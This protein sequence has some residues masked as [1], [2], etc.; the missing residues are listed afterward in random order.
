MAEPLDGT[1]TGFLNMPKLPVASAR[2]RFLAFFLDLIL[3]TLAVYLLSKSAREVFFSWGVYYTYVTMLLTFLYFALFDSKIGRGRTPGKVLLGLTVTDYDGNF[4]PLA[5]SI[6][7][8][9]VLMPAFFM[10]PIV[11]SL[12]GDVDSVNEQY[13]RL[14]LVP[15]PVLCVFLANLLIIPFNPFKQ[16]M[17]D[18][19]AKTLVRRAAPPD[20]VY[21]IFEEMAEQ[22]G[23]AWPKYYRQ[24][25]LS[26]VVTF[27]LIF[28]VLAF[29]FYPGRYPQE[30]LNAASASYALEDIP[31]HGET[32]VEFF[33]DKKEDYLKRIPAYFGEER[34]AK[35]LETY[36]MMGDAPTTATASLVVEVIRHNPWPL[37]PGQGGTEAQAAAFLEAYYRNVLPWIV[38]MYRGSE[39]LYLQD[40]S[41]AVTGRPL[42][43]NVV[44][45]QGLRTVPPVVNPIPQG[46]YTKSFPPLESVPGTDE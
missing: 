34:D 3:I 42:E 24:P 8:T 33:P 31:G 32:S 1:P 41:D 7:R 29:L 46:F 11:D 22:V 43:L 45:L 39:N 20:T 19:L 28:I 25:Q 27:A 40:I 35:A 30:Y 12:I 44:Y 10:G 17:H 2:R 23:A 21:P 37:V 38:V 14:L 6:L 5:Q 9:V 16:G 13:A 36:L 4:I 15:F 18:H 26:G